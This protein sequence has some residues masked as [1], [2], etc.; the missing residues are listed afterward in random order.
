MVWF[1]SLNQFPDETILPRQYVCDTSKFD[2]LSTGEDSADI[3]EASEVYL[4]L[5][6]FSRMIVESG[7]ITREQFVHACRVSSA[8]GLP[9]GRALVLQK[10]I[11]EVRLA[12]ILDICQRVEEGTLSLEEAFETLNF[13]LHHFA[14][15]HDGDTFHLKAR[16]GKRFEELLVNSKLVSKTDLLTA[17]EISLVRK[18]SL[19]KTLVA[20]CYLIE[21]AI[22]IA[23]NLLDKINRGEINFQQGVKCLNQIDWEGEKPTAE[24]LLE[25]HLVKP[26]DRSVVLSPGRARS[27]P[28]SNSLDCSMEEEVSEATLTTTSQLSFGSGMQMYEKL[29]EACDRTAVAFLERCDY[30]QAENVYRRVLALSA[31]KQ[32]SPC[33]IRA[34]ANLAELVSKRGAHADA[35]ALMNQIVIL[36][37]SSESYDGLQLA[38]YLSKLSEMYMRAGQYCDAEPPLARALLIREGLLPDG[39]PGLVANLRAYG[40]LLVILDRNCEAEKLFVQSQTETS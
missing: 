5:S 11:T 16:N 25:R 6:L 12:T 28:Q 3:D 13:V 29:M 39:H 36:L 24:G 23:T 26:D 33:Q 30:K 2:A 35:A 10:A 4:K 37:D 9:V 38:F 31:P 18:E 7:L 40:A 15:S 34:I 14:L 27:T 8:T 19:A 32:G 22:T 17:I 21:P 20:L 1:N